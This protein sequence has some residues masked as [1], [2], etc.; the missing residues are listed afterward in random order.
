MGHSQPLSKRLQST[1]KV[2]TIDNN[3]LDSVHKMIL[4]Q[5]FCLFP[6][7]FVLL[8]VILLVLSFGPFI[9][10][11]PSPIEILVQS[12]N[13]GQSQLVSDKNRC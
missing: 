1:V 6:Q 4:N 8:F 7:T 2:E 11:P 10:A 3:R 9:N 12:I 13:L 5:S